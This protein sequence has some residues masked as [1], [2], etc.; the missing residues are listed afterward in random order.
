MRPPAPVRG[1]YDQ[2]EL[3]QGRG[4]AHL[5]K[6]A[7]DVDR[8]KGRVLGQTF[9]DVAFNQLSLYRPLLRRLR[10]RKP[11]GESVDEHETG[12]VVRIGAGIK[13]ADQTAV[14]MGDEHVGP[15]L[16]G[17]TQQGMQIGD[18]RHRRGGLRNRV[19]PARFLTHRRSR[20]IIGTDPGELGDLGKHPRPWPLS[21]SPI[22]GGP[23]QAGHQ[24]D[25]RGPDAATLQIHLAT[26]ARVDQSGEISALP[27]MRGRRV[28]RR[29]DSNNK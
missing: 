13:P 3:A 11:F 29:D 15:R 14:G 7:I 6:A 27:G 16:A 8:F 28:Q 22:L 26:S 1:Q 18:R 17:G 12:Y 23:S 21:D 5:I 19:A 25:G 10:V 4:G 24:H 20:T 9:P 2:G